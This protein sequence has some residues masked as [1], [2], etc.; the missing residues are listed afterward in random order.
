MPSLQPPPQIKK[1][2]TYNRNF[3]S[4]KLDCRDHT[5]SHHPP[6]FIYAKL[7]I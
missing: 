3:L 7:Y 5:P 1:K 2:K 4:V 6:I